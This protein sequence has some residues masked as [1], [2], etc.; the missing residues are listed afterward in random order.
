MHGHRNY[1]TRL[2]DIIIN[3]TTPDEINKHQNW[4]K[5]PIPT[6]YFQPKQSQI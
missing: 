1:G 6:D 5:D 2:W 3:S 4:V